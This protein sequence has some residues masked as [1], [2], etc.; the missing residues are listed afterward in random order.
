M[1]IQQTTA[2]LRRTFRYPADEDSPDTPEAMDEEEQEDLVRTLA[3]QNAAR[4]AQFRQLLLALPLLSAA[5]YL[6]ALLRPSPS[7]SS[8][9]SVSLLALSSLASTAYLLYVL[10]P[11]LTGIP[12]LDRRGSRAGAGRGEREGGKPSSPLEQHLPYLNLA[13]CGV[14]VLAG[15]LTGRG[16]GAGA[17]GALGN[18][19]PAAV[20]GVVLL[21]KTVMA[22][23]DPEAELGGLK[24]EYKGA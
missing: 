16:K 10:P 5:P 20:Y 6:L 24:Y 23:V 21:A 1:D 14:L 4:N 12:Y 17:L 18:Y 8:S 22:G 13:L 3:A 7:S 11:T 9:P 19:L 15:L 2:R